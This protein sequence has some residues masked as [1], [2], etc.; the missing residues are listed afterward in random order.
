[1]IKTIINVLSIAVPII[2][3]VA[4]VFAGIVGK[5]SKSIIAVAR[6]IL[7]AIL[8]FVFARLFSG[9]LSNIFTPIAKKTFA[10]MLGNNASILTDELLDVISAIIT[11][12]SSLMIFMVA[13]LI[14]YLLLMIP[15][16][17]INK[18]LNLSERMKAPKFVAP[19]IRVVSGLCTFI[20]LVSPLSFIG[21]TMNSKAINS[22]TYNGT[23]ICEMADTL[24][25]SI[26]VKIA[27]AAGGNLFFDKITLMK[28]KGHR[29][30]LADEA[31]HTL[32]TVFSAIDA[33]NNKDYS[34]LKDSLQDVENSTILPEMAATIISNSAQQWKENDELFGVKL[35]INSPALMSLKN[36]ALDIFANWTQ[37]DIKKNYASVLNIMDFV[38]E[39]KLD[40][41]MSDKELEKVIYKDNFIPK[42]FDVLDENED[43]R[44]IIPNVVNNSMG[45]VLDELGIQHSI[46]DTSMDMSKI[47]AS[48]VK[49]EAAI[50]SDIAQ[51]LNNELI[52]TGSTD[53]TQLPIESA[54]KVCESLNK[55]NDS[56][57]LNDSAKSYLPAIYEKIGVKN[58]LGDLS[59]QI[60]DEAYNNIS[61]A[62]NK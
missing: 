34:A 20:L 45:M 55:V 43:M 8:A 57:F 14:L 27:G 11:G 6:N 38:S 16:Y 2:V 61:N 40:Q 50:I 35:N 30:V 33:F 58:I 26:A 37:E 49:E 29:L 42:L 24:D 53:I 36:S 15:G 4:C 52:S 7:A 12:I 21:R 9:A 22:T 10:T 1:M 48:T 25:S 13:Y 56:A 51:T 41:G 62:V 59:G 54:A 5:F 28:Y 3:I 17:I 47:S 31:R 39:Y 18:K 23:I 19:V 32:R 44:T 46:E 60:S